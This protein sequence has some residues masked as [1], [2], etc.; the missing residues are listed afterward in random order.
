MGVSRLESLAPRAP[1]PGELHPRNT[2]YPF[3][4]APGGSTYPAA[5]DLFLVEEVNSFQGF[6]APHRLQREE[7]RLRAPPR[8][9]VNG[10]FQGQFVRRECQAAAFYLPA[11]AKR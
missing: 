8:P 10:V 5:P 3:N 11:C 9:G 6:N 2:E 4:D 7:L 1:A